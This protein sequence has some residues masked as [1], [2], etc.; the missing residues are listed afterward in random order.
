MVFAKHLMEAPHYNRSGMKYPKGASCLGRMS[1]FWSILPSRLRADGG[2]FYTS[3][4]PDLRLT[5][6]VSNTI[7]SRSTSTLVTISR[8]GLFWVDDCW[9]HRGRVTCTWLGPDSGRGPGVPAT[10]LQTALPLKTARLKELLK[11]P[12]KYL[13]RDSG[14]MSC[15]S[16]WTPHPVATETGPECTPPNSVGA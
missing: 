15:S 14:R 11:P 9:G 12:H 6:G 4:C 5:L 3:Q 7:V 16:Y 13:C 10:L 8:Q 1:C 2:P